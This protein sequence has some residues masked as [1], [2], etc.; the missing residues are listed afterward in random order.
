MAD[1]P[2]I[3]TPATQGNTDAPVATEP[4]VEAPTTPGLMGGEKAPE[5][6]GL[7]GEKADGETK[8]DPAT[9]DAKEGEEN[10]LEGAPESYGEFTLNDSYQMTDADV[11]EFTAYAKDNNWSKETAQQALNLDMAR[12][13]KFAKSQDETLKEWQTEV[14]KEY[15]DKY[16][17][18]IAV[19]GKAYDTFASKKLQTLFTEAGLNSHPEVVKMFNAMGKAISEDSFVKGGNA[20]KGK[21]EGGL[22]DMFSDLNNKT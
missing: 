17:E 15:G 14:K 19:A 10:T 6:E 9:S 20:V 16:A 12:Q 21:N 8:D 4:V 18:E 1:E 2:T 3:A 13:A 7:M 5:A 11:E 22:K